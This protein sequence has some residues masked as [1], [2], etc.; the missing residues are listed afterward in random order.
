MS[1]PR[2]RDLSP[3]DRRAALTA[4][5]NLGSADLEQLGFEPALPPATADGMI[6]NVIGTFELPLGVATN[7]LI[8]G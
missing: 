1:P 4:R 6:E 7:F 8:N 2:L 5:T 3:D